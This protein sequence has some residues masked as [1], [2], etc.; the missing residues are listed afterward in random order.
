V[1][2]RV[3]GQ[4]TYL[5]EFQCHTPLTVS[6]SCM[7]YHRRTIESSESCSYSTTSIRDRSTACDIVTDK[8]SPAVAERSHD[9]S[10][11]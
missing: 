8:L 10:C 9:A 5:E 11:H 6:V 4:S 7:R 3:S 1:T 2:A